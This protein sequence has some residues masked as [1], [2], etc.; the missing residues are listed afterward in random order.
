MGANPTRK[1]DKQ[2][3]QP[4]GDDERHQCGNDAQPKGHRAAGRDPQLPFNDGQESHGRE[5]ANRPGF[6]KIS[7]TRQ[8]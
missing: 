7:F 6:G 3:E 8:A 4:A 2:G 5:L 1:V